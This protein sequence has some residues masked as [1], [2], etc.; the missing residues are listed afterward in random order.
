MSKA[1]IITAKGAG[2]YSVDLNFNTDVIEFNIERLRLRQADIENVD[3][4]QAEQDLSDAQAALDDATAKMN[5]L[6]KQLGGK[7]SQALLDALNAATADLAT[8]FST[9]DQVQTDLIGA[10][11]NFQNAQIHLPPAPPQPVLDAFATAVAALDAAENARFDEQQDVQPAQNYLAAALTD[12][13]TTPPDLIDAQNQVSQL[14]EHLGTISGDNIL[15][16]SNL[17]DSKS[18]VQA[19]RNTLPAGASYDLSRADLDASLAQLDVAIADHGTLAALYSDTDSKA[20]KAQDLLTP[21]RDEI[22]KQVKEALKALND[23]RVALQAAQLARDTLELELQEIERKIDELTAIPTKESKDLWCAD[24]TEDLPAGTE[25]GTMEV[26]GE[27]DGPQAGAAVIRPAFDHQH[28]WDNGRDG[29]LTPCQALTAAAT[30]YNLAML[31]GWQVFKPIFRFAVVQAINDDGTLKVGLIQ[32]NISSQQSIDVTPKDLQTN[33]FL[34]PQQIHY[35]N[36]PVHYMDCDAEAFSVGDEVVVQYENQMATT[37]KVIGFRDHPRECQALRIATPQGMVFFDVTTNAWQFEAKTGLA[38]GNFNWFNVKLRL[39]VSI[40]GPLGRHCLHW[41]LDTPIYHRGKKITDAPVDVVYGGVTGAAISVV[42]TVKTLICVTCEFDTTLNESG[43]PNRIIERCWQTPLDTPDQWVKIGEHAW[44]A[45]DGVGPGFD[46][47]DVG[48]PQNYVPF[49]FWHFNE[50]VT[51]AVS[52]KIFDQSS[53]LGATSDLWSQTWML[54]IAD[55]VAN[56]SG[57][58]FTSS[59]TFRD[60]S[61]SL[62]VVGVAADYRGDTLVRADI[63]IGWSDGV[64][65]GDPFPGSRMLIVGDDSHD[66]GGSADEGHGVQ[67]GNYVTYVDLRAEQPILV[68]RPNTYDLDPPSDYPGTWYLALWYQGVDIGLSSPELAPSYGAE[69]WANR[70][71]FG[72]MLVGTSKLF[73]D[74]VSQPVGTFAIDDKD[75][76]I[77]SDELFQIDHMEPERDLIALTIASGF[78]SPIGLIS[79]PKNI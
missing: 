8:A 40:R 68:Y 78:V 4:P 43:R 64:A 3:L 16:T 25:I 14:I 31:P 63:L 22:K 76:F 53:H 74:P 36:V 50:S 51:Q 57:P 34:D 13:T 17:N 79:K 66:L 20:H 45:G 1:T 37:P 30:F 54:D 29:W 47:G 67:S 11:A 60:Q 35:D 33:P 7:P 41:Y 77:L 56:F 6:I 42:G 55:G 18:K 2:L 59:E 21:G 65:D 9:L 28:L 62:L 72:G 15:T 12:V 44:N 73:N 39:E 61:G 26:P 19:A 70:F 49:G 75:H 69:S 71:H 27:L 10:S 52:V 24:L 32:P 58:T 5:E 46:E 23:A 38:Y 48:Y